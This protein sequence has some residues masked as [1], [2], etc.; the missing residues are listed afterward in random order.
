[1]Q[2]AAKYSQLPGSPRNPRANSLLAW[3]DDVWTYVQTRWVAILSGATPP[4]WEELEADID[5]NHPEP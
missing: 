4:T 5:A 1:M 3:E 2:K